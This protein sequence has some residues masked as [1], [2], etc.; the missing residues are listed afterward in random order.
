MAAFVFIG[1]G[2]SDPEQTSVF[3]YKFELNGAP[4]EVDEKTAGKLATNGHFKVADSLPTD[5]NE[6]EAIAAKFGVEIDKRKTVATLQRQVQ[7]L[8]DGNQDAV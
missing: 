8:I 6:L 2:K 5:K 1:N 4:V 7:E 3:G